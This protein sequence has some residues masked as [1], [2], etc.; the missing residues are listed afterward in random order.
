MPSSMLRLV[1][2]AQHQRAR[3]LPSPDGGVAGACDGMARGVRTRQADGEVRAAAGLRVQPDR[4]VEHPADALDDRQAE[5]QPAHG[6]AVSSSRWNSL[7]IARCLARG[8]RGRCRRPRRRR[9]SPR[10]RQP[11]STLPRGV[12]LMALET[13]FCRTRRS[14]RRSERTPAAS[15][16][17]ASRGPSRAPAAR[18]PPRGRRAR[19]A[20]RNTVIS[21]FSAPVSSREMSS[22]TPMISSTASSEASMLRT[23]VRS[24]AARPCA[25]PGSWHRAGPRSAAAGC[26]GRRRPGSASCRDWLRRPWPWHRQRL[27]DPR[28]LRGALAHAPLERLLGAL[29]ARSVMSE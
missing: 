4:M 1:V 26:R 27:V 19:R 15:A 16:R 14:S 7:K 6:P 23:S 3:R 21:G 13:R 5:P 10:R 8:C 12:Y 17:Y 22:R 28:Q 20:R 18:T 11:T 25:R 24:G 9:R 29:H 2:D